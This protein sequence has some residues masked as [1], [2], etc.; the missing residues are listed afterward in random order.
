MLHSIFLG[1]LCQAI[2]IDKIKLYSFG[3]YQQILIF[4]HGFEKQ[5][6]YHLLRYATKWMQF[7]IKSILNQFLDDSSEPYQ[8]E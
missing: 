1:F 7:L 5:I 4:D 6:N 2:N 3:F 8:A